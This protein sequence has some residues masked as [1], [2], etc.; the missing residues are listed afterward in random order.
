M[1]LETLKTFITLVNVGNFTQTAQKH[2]VVQSTI[3]SR[4]KE[5]ENEV[6][7]QLFTR[8]RKNLRLTPAGEQLFTYATQI[9][10]LGEYALAELN[11]LGIY[12]D[13]LRIGS[14]QTLYDCHISKYLPDYIKQHRDISVKII[15]DHTKNLLNMLYDNVI[16]LCFTYRK[17][18]HSSYQNLLFRTDPI[19][20]VTGCMN[21]NYSHG[22]T[23]EQL[24]TIPFFYSDFV[25]VGDSS[26]FHSIFPKHSVYQ[27]N[28]DILN[29][30]IPLIK[31]GLGY[32]FL[33]KSAVES[34][35]NDGSLIEIPLLDTSVPPLQSYVVFKNNSIP[36]KSVSLW[37]ESIFMNLP[38]NNDLYDS[39][40]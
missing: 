3:S 6:G 28:I 22:I 26:W 20:L 36:K 33:P 17:F 34:D 8:D 23:N 10:T 27:L 11:M 18:Y 15:L 1:D 32:S 31:E 21:Q 39:N 9:I 30:L 12:T 7:Q 16:D 2:H 37:L 14:V 4:I 29:K 38:Q 40:K 35:L 25:E 19:I 5:L 13:S 24:R